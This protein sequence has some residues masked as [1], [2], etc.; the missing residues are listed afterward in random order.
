MILRNFNQVEWT[1]NTPL[2]NGQNLIVPLGAQDATPVYFVARGQ[3]IRFMTFGVFSDRIFQIVI[4]Q[5]W[6]GDF[7]AGTVNAIA[8]LNV[9]AATYTQPFALPAPQGDN[10]FIVLQGDYI[11]CRAVDT[12]AGDHAQT[13]L[14]FAAWA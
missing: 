1:Y 3:D 11:R 6:R 8:T 12:S 7:A 13:N 4:E 14:Y 10:G 2:T 5:S 9:L